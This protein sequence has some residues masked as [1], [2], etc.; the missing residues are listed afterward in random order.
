MIMEGG[1]P[2]IIRSFRGEQKE[3][4][5]SNLISAAKGISEAMGEKEIK[6]LDFGGDKLILTE[7]RKRYTVVAL[8]GEAVGYIDKIIQSIAKEIDEHEKIPPSGS[9]IAEQDKKQIGEIIDTYEDILMLEAFHDW[10]RLLNKAE[11]KEEIFSYALSAIKRTLGFK[12][13]EVLMQEGNT[14]KV[15]KVVGWE[16]PEER[17]IMSLEGTGIIVKTLRTGKTV[18][19]DNVTDYPEYVAACPGIR[20][21]LA[22]PIKIGEDVIG[23]LNIESEKENAFDEE[24]KRLIELI[25]SHMGITIKKLREKTRIIERQKHLEV[26]HE[27]AL[28]LNKADK[29][30]EILNYTLDAIEMTLGFEHADVGLIEDNML[31][32]EQYRGF[33]FPQDKLELPLDESGLTIKAVKS[34]ETILANDVTQHPEYITL[35]S[36]LS[37]ELVVPIMIDDEVIGVLNV[38]DTEKNA[39]DRQGKRLLEILASHVAIAIK[40]LREKT[41]RREIEKKL[42][43]LHKWAQRLNKADT[44]D[45]ILAYTLDAIEDTLGFENAII[46]LKED[47]MLK[48]AETLG[49]KIPEKQQEL[50]VNGKGIAVKAVNTGNPILVNNVKEDPNFLP[51]NPRIKSEIAIPITIEKEVLG[52]IDLETT[53]QNAYHQ[54]DQHLLEILASHVAV[55]IKK[56]REKKQLISYKTQRT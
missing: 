30:T 51:P 42:S 29:M 53:R 44:M 6:R 5:F 45:K 18:V 43:I 24:D 33:E 31:K 16:I 27:W 50:P 39:F 12:H 48:A 55:A 10:V 19:A 56:F 46:G 4:L 9:M 2:V 35:S 49:L 14:L 7:S 40:K 13:A 32:F 34:R 54:R 38:E 47:D 52:V 11:G 41:Y 17:R 26:F 23:V 1:V 15:E 25:A 8:V 28:R 3:R 22:A 20:S 36:D 37:S 21:E